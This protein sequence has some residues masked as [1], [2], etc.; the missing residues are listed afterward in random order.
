MSILLLLLLFIANC[1]K[2]NY[3]CQLPFLLFDIW[4]SSKQKNTLVKIA[5]L[6]VNLVLSF[7]TISTNVLLA[8]F[9][10]QLVIELVVDTN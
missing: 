2:I 4:L 6:I 9:F 1:L 3:F 8:V 5:F 10:L 7:F